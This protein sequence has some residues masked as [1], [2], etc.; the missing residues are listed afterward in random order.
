MGRQDSLLSPRGRQD[1]LHSPRHRDSKMTERTPK[2]LNLKRQLTQVTSVEAEESKHS[3][4]LAKPIFD[5]EAYLMSMFDKVPLSQVPLETQ[6][7]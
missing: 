5:K 1:S 7:N 6:I 3:T 4:K 2:S